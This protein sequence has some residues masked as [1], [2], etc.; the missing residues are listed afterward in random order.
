MVLDIA[1]ADDVE[2][3]VVLEL[4]EHVLQR[5]AEDVGEHV[6]AAAVRHTEH[7]VADSAL[8]GP[9][10]Q[11]V[12]YGDQGFAPFQRET[13][14]AEEFL[15]QKGLEQ[16]RFGEPAEDVELFVGAVGRFVAA[17]FHPHA[18]PLSLF[19]LLDVG[20]LDPDRPAIGVAQGGDDLAQGGTGNV[21]LLDLEGGVEV[22][23]GKAEGVEAEQ[24]VLDLAGRERVG[25]GEQMADVAVAP[26][27]GLHCHRLADQLRGDRI[28]SRS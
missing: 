8:P 27:Q 16:G 1:V 20:K 21:E 3:E 22:G 17:L 7:Q 25:A 23:L 18:Q 12:E 24:R 6:E 19:G 28:A 9:L 14:L 10:D 13:L 5:L 2:L 15:V 11:G 4:G 26:D